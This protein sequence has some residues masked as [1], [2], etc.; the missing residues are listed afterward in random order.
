[1]SINTQYKSRNEFRH[2]LQLILILPIK[3]AIRESNEPLTYHI[4]K[5]SQNGFKLNYKSFENTL[6]GRNWGAYQFDYYQKLYEYFN[7]NLDVN[8]FALLLTDS[9]AYENKFRELKSNDKRFKKLK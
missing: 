9:I 6:R 5:M 4:D 7:V 2:K 1:M 8:T 3:K